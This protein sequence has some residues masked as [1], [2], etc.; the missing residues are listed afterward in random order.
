[1]KMINAGRSRAGSSPL[2]TAPRLEESLGHKD[3][4]V[5]LDEDIGIPVPSPHQLININPNALFLFSFSPEDIYPTPRGQLSE[6]SRLGDGSDKGQI[7]RVLD[8]AGRS[9][10]ALHEHEVA[11][12][13][14]D[15]VS[16]L[17]LD[18]LSQV[19]PLHELGE[20]DGDLFV[21]SQ[22]EPFFRIGGRRDSPD[23]GHRLENRQLARQLHHAWLPEP[24][25]EVHRPA[26]DLADDDGD[27]GALDR[28]RIDGGEVVLEL[29]H[30]LARRLNLT[31]QG[32]RGLPVRP[33]SPCP[34][35]PC[36][37]QRR[38]M[39]RGTT[40]GSSRSPR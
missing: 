39:L 34:W 5:G 33:C 7:L 6:A 36:F 11:E 26:L 4:V 19:P 30:A 25:Y 2:G 40:T 15:R 37:G 18:V 38:G 31:D 29:L 27:R 21:L 3:D 32:E 17:K 8:R 23:Q 28:L 22:H 1:M 12:W 13:R 10:L 35:S 9:D 14:H 16:R 24:A 20:I